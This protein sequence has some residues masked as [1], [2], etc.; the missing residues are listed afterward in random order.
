LVGLGIL[1]LE[2]FG[3]ALRLRWPWYEWTEPDRAWVGLGN[4]CDGKDMELFYASINLSI[5]DGKTAKFWHSPWLGGFKPKD[6]APSILAISKKK[7][8]TVRKALDHDFWISN[9]IF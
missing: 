6:I 4:P 7:N 5:G 2:R 8:F 1:D 3:R 9:L